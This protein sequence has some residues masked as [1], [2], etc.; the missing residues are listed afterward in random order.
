MYEDS[1]KIIFT[2]NDLGMIHAEILLNVV[3]IN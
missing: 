2:S 3:D 1:G